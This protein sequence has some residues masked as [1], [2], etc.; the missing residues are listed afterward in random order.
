MYEFFKSIKLAINMVLGKV[1]NEK[2]F[3]TF[4]FMKS[5]SRNQ[6]TTHLDLVVRMYAQN[7][8]TFQSFPFYIAITKWNEN[9]SHYGLEL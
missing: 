5:K 1:E 3:S 6:L 2:T 8:F 9:K 7:L 4:I